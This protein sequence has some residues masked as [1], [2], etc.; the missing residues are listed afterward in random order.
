LN[1]SAQVVFFGNTKHKHLLYL[2]KITANYE[3]LSRIFTVRGGIL[4][5]HISLI[6]RLDESNRTIIEK[7]IGESILDELDIGKIERFDVLNSRD[8]H[9][10]I[11]GFE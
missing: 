3:S 10:V 5:N 7:G 8:Y 1:N 4:R 6:E 2:R 9:F 11:I